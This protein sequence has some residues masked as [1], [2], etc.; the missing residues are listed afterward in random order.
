M[1]SCQ[2]KTLVACDSCDEKGNCNLHLPCVNRG[3]VFTVQIFAPC[4]MD[5][6]LRRANSGYLPEFSH[7]PLQQPALGRDHQDKPP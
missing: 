2:G 5:D 4:S 1:L 7:L 6:I 3:L